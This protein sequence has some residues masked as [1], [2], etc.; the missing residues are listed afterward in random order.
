MSQKN[1]MSTMHKLQ[2]G[3]FGKRNSG[4]SAL[5]NA[6]LGQNADDITETKEPIYKAM[7]IYGI[8]SVTLV[9]TAGIDSS[10]KINQQTQAA[11]EKIDIALMLI[12]NDS[13]ELEL[14][15]MNRLTRTGTLVIPV[16]SQI[17]KLNDGGKQLAAAVLEASGKKPICIS[18]KQNIG[19]DE[20]RNEIILKIQ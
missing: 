5:I 9:D 4:K 17:D 20:L 11:A 10:K 2:I 8:G 13:I 19:I 1:E 3:I 18:A 7:D 14:A 6:L 12:S 16:V 15:W